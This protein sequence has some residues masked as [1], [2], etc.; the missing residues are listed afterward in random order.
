MSTE[1]NNKTGTTYLN[2]LNEFPLSCTGTYCY[3][4][5]CHRN[6]WNYSLDQVRIEGVYYYS[7]RRGQ[8]AAE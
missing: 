7:Y 6:N 3:S 8:R 4:Y 1:T 5:E 2:A